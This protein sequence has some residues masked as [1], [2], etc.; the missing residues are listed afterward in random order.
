MDQKHAG[1]TS[2]A[3]GLDH[4]GLNFT[5]ACGNTHVDGVAQIE[6]RALYEQI[7]TRTAMP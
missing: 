1:L 2:A 4:V 7:M 3:F 6:S 5:F